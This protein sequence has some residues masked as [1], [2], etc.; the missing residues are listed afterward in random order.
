MNLFLIRWLKH[1][2]LARHKTKAAEM[3]KRLAQGR[4]GV[5]IHWSLGFLS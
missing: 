1:K 3:L 5:F 2:K 4:P